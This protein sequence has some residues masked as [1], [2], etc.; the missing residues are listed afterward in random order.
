VRAVLAD[1]DGQA[2]VEYVL[3]IMVLVVIIITL[4]KTLK[5]QMLNLVQGTI[6]NQINNGLFAN[7]GVHKFRL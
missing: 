6:G 5:G 7:G 2:A 1:E 3:L 4:G